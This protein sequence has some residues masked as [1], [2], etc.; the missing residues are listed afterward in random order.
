MAV[1]MLGMVGIG[2]DTIWP[3]FDPLDYLDIPYPH[4]LRYATFIAP[5]LAFVL[6]LLCRRSNL[7]NTLAFLIPLLTIA[8][9]TN[10]ADN[11]PV[12][13]HVTKWFEY[14]QREAEEKQLGFKVYEIDGKDGYEM[15]V[16]RTPGRA[17]LLTAEV[18]RL[19]IW[20][21]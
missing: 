5:G 13:I 6:W 15:W 2:V 18:K 20:R 3:A 4:L 14:D 21:T 7:V 12:K 19:G 16:D 17:N 11:Q 1:L 10:W 8:T 9:V